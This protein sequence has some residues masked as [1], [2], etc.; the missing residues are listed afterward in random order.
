MIDRYCISHT[1]PLLPETWYD[2]CISLGDFQP[3]SEFHVRHLDRFWHDARPVAYGA[4]G[5]YV[6]P[7]AVQRS[8][9][10]AEFIEI[11]NYR[12]R[13]L[14]SPEGTES[15][16]YPTLRE[17][18][19]VTFQKAAELSTFVPS[20]ENGFLIAQPLHVKKSIFGHYKAVHRRQD[21]LDYTSLAVE[22][23]ILDKPSASEFLGA[24]HFIP[25]G[26]ELGVYPKSWLIPALSSLEVLGREFLNRYGSRVER[27]NSFQ[28]RAVGF[29][30]ERLG[31]FLL[32][33][34]LTKKYSNN[35]PA[36]IF[37][38]MTVIVEGGSGY[39]AGLTDRSKDRINSRNSKH[40][41]A[42]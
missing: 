22:L 32:I 15:R 37:G 14:P 16:K 21:I 27:Y 17:L 13:I 18:D 4:A 8:F 38:H 35:I 34:H 12:K 25:G 19:L 9:A 10:D 3:E 42:R 5:T 24:K 36:N 40:S 6:V 39:T 28:V 2:H 26:I 29:L 41:H 31:S 23:G 30:S 1:K 7:V 20:A 11:S 33:R